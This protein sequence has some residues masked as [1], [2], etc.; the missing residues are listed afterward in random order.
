M[1]MKRRMLPV[2]L[3]L[4]LILT[5]PAEAFAQEDTSEIPTIYLT[6][7]DPANEGRAFVDASKS[8]VTAGFMKLTDSDGTTVY[9]GALTQIKARGNS[10]FTYADKKS[11]QIKLD[12]KTDLLGTGEKVKTWVLLA[13]YNDATKVHDKTWKDFAAS[14]GMPY[15]ASSNW[16][17]L[18]YDGEYRGLYLL[19]EKNQVNKT[20]VDIFDMEEAYADLNEAYGEDPEIQ[21]GR[22]K[23]GQRFKYTADL[24]EPEDLSG[25]YLLELNHTEIDEASGFYTRKGRAVNVK[26][27]EWAGKDAMEYISEFFQEFE[28]AVYA[29]DPAG[30]YTG[31]NAKTGKY[32]YDYVDKDSLVKTFLLKELAQNPDDF[33]FS[34]FL[35]KDRGSDK[36]FFGPI[37]DQE[38]IFGTGWN[39]QFSPTESVKPYLVSALLRIPDF[40]DAVMEYYQS[41]FSAE[42]GKLLGEEGILAKNTAL[43]R[44][45]V[46]ADHA[47]WPFVK[48]GNPRMEGRLW[49]EDATYQ[50][51]VDEMTAWI[52][53]R[54]AFLDRLYGLTDCPGSAYYALPVHW[55]IDTGVTNGIDKTHFGPELSCT[56][57]QM[58]T[59]LWRAAGSPETPSQ[60]AS[61]T[62]PPQRGAKECP[63]TD[64]A[65]DAYYY[66]A[67]LWAVEQGITTGTSDTTFSPDAAI[68]RGQSVTFLYRMKNPSQSASQTAPPKGGA[69]ECSFIDVAEDA[70]YYDAVLWA[71]ENGITTGKTDSLFAPDDDCTRAQIVTFLYRAMVK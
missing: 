15:V 3:A 70:Y 19:S 37:W 26:S 31:Y 30:N 36:L 44:D 45:S 68:T 25:G 34:T 57:A 63:F 42:A 61:Q 29:T 48:I 71:A 56:R 35:Y 11:Y 50:D 6:S 60:S 4:L 62:A 52:E 55:A 59:F 2:L 27:P 8:N 28:D 10:T 12:K 67:V 24:N 21:A 32:Y 13:G 41:T 14:L 5:I 64:V 7:S 49:E 18:Y 58:V 40:R 1:L 47:L 9:D 38:M 22:N 17:N 16:V 69:E 20:S 23:Y 33:I 43:V 46:L 51:V 53:E 65:E 54:I 39:R 66:R